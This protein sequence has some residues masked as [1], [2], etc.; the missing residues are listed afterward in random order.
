[1]S[2]F[3]LVAHSLA[4]AYLYLMATPCAA[5]GQGPLR[6]AGGTEVEP[7]KPELHVALNVHLRELRE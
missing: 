1:M 4:E 2:D 5:C 6:A 3:P 7:D